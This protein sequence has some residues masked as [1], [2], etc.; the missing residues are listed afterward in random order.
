MV[1][2]RFTRWT[3]H[4]EGRKQ[5]QDKRLSRRRKGAI[6]I[7]PGLQARYRA[8]RHS[9]PTPLAAAFALG[10][11]FLYAC[12][13]AVWKRHAMFTI[14]FVIVQGREHPRV[15]ERIVSQARHLSDVN[16]TARSQL[17]MVRQKHSE[18]PPD[19]YQILDSQGD[20][21]LRSW[22]RT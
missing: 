12:Q 10:R 16:I 1:S 3:R 13:E 4:R 7:T 22:E 2:A 18:T 9:P 21:V 14:E 8:G 15:V 19:G 17:E 20:I 11:P 5:C 6:G